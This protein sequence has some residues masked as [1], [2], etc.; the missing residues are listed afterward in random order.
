MRGRGR[1]RR[2]DDLLPI[3]DISVLVTAVLPDSTERLRSLLMSSSDSMSESKSPIRPSISP[4]TT[5]CSAF[6]MILPERNL[7]YLSRFS[8]V[9]PTGCVSLFSAISG[10]RRRHSERIRSSNSGKL[11]G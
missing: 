8:G 1:S 3:S 5:H 4:P 9:S 11:M 6:G 10:V 2:G 7:L